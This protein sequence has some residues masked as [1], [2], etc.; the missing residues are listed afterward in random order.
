MRALIESPS[1]T[2]F[3]RLLD[4]ASLDVSGASVCAL[5]GVLNLVPVRALLARGPLPYIV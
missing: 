2:N 3:C 5:R 1:C 4:A